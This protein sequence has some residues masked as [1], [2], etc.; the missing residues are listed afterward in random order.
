M[1]DVSGGAALIRE[2]VR[3]SIAR[4]PRKSRPSAS[5]TLLARQ[6]TPPSVVT[7]QVPPL[8]LAHTFRPS[9]AETPRSDARVLLICGAQVCAW[10]VAVKHSA[11]STFMFSQS[12]SLAPAHAIPFSALSPPSPPHH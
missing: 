9:T 5:G 11:S 7:S 8:P 6:V 3:A 4:I 10:R 12:Y 2:T 1:G